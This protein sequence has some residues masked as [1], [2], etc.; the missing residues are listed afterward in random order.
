MSDNDF[1]VGQQ[2]CA[3]FK[4]Q[5][6]GERSNRHQ[7][8]TCIDGIRSFCANCC[9]DHHQFGWKTCKEAAK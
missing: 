2:P 9:F 1:T 4:P 8:Y 3:D 6:E 7:C 5:Q